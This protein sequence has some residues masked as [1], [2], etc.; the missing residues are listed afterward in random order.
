MDFDEQEKLWLAMPLGEVLT[1]LEEKKEELWGEAVGSDLAGK[2]ESY[3]GYER[4]ESLHTSLAR[5]LAWLATMRPPQHVC[6]AYEASKEAFVGKR[7]RARGRVCFACRKQI[8]K[9]QEL[10]IIA[11]I[12]MPG[13]PVHEE[14]FREIESEFGGRA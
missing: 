12:Q 9:T 13:L 14:C 7:L 10:M 1:W 2:P 5:V 11:P 3:Q 6:D 4:V 8:R